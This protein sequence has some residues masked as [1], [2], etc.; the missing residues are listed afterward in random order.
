MIKIF[1]FLAVALLACS[2]VRAQSEMP[3]LMQGPTLNA[4]HIVFAY[5]GELWRVSR[6]GGAALQLTSGPGQKSNPHFSPDGKWIAFTAQY[7]GNLNVYLLSA[8]GGE[9]RQLSFGRGPDTVEG[10]TADGKSVLFRSSLKSYSVRFE[11][12]YT[13]S[14]EGGPTREVPLPMGYEGS[15]SSDGTHL[16]YTPLPR[17][18]FFLGDDLVHAFWAHY[19]GGLAPQ[20][21]I[22][23]LADSATIK[24]PHENASDFNP[25]WVGDKIY[26]LS[27]RT[28]PITL[29]A[30]QTDSKQ[31]SRVV[32]NHGK[33]IMSASAG[34]GAIVYEQFGSLHLFDLASGREHEVH[35]EIH[36]DFPEV[37]PHF[38]KV[39]EHILDANISPTG[40]RA[41]FE[42]H[43]DIITVPAE[44][45]D[46]RNLTNSPAVAE[47]SPAWSPDGRSIAYLFR[48]APESLVR[49]S[50]QSR[51]SEDRHRYLFLF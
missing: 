45:G 5:A 46:A 19:H 38:E 6:E 13:I 27:A 17:E 18:I 44:K 10:W 37:R 33:D 23:N 39:A 24:V 11:Q 34:P 14:T 21:W 25:M 50:E 4:S 47:R 22:A 32:E 29:Y 2:L 15:Y 12:L 28:E 40:A 7:G 51:A 3:L 8:E 30:Y 49:G 20:V 36:G 26:F 42:A 35:V 41:V 43:G 48:Q 31:V 16:A 9:A 1:G